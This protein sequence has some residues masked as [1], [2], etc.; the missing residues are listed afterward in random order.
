M[1]SESSEEGR[2]FDH[3]LGEPHAG[4][5]DLA[6]PEGLRDRRDSARGGLGLLS[7]HE[8]RAHDT[9]AAAGLDDEREAV[10]ARVARA[11]VLEEVK[12]VL[13]NRDAIQ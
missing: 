3:L 1:R 6:R 5:G 12:R 2:G 9:A 7:A 10:T 11:E 4:L 13:R 8:R